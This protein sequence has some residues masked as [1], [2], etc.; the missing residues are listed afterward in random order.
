MNVMN[1]LCFSEKVNEKI[2]GNFISIYD[3]HDDRYQYFV[4]RLIGIEIE[5]PQN[6]RSAKMWIPYINEKK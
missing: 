2:D 6:P 4:Q 5:D 3:E 1:G